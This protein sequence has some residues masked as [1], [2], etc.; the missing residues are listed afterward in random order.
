V[1]G[2]HPPDER[3]RTLMEVGGLG[4]KRGEEGSETLGL[5][6]ESAAKTGKQFVNTGIILYLL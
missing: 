6:E 1:I 4:E 5:L 2:G 3:A